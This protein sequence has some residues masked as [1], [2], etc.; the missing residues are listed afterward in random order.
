[1]AQ[2]QRS[3]F[4]KQIARIPPPPQQATNRVIGDIGQRLQPKPEV[5]RE[6]HHVPRHGIVEG[7]DANASAM[8]GIRFRTFSS[9]A[10]AGVRPAGLFMFADLRPTPAVELNR[11]RA[12]LSE[13][14][15]RDARTVVAEALRRFPNNEALYALSKLTAPSKAALSA[16]RF[17]RREDELRWLE[18]HRNQYK[19]RWVALLGNELIASA[20]T[21][22]QLL[23]AVAAKN[24]EG[25]PLI[26]KVV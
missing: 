12:L 24:I 17:P 15:L 14:L 7:I 16:V 13:G 23:D 1:M 4:D 9:A 5:W 18:E 6:S 8:M 25:S 11:I 26:H 3:R 21:M 2:Q 10:E 19:R 22:K 20:D